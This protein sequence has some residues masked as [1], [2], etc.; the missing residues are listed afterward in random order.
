[1][2]DISSV[3]DRITKYYKAR[4]YKW[5]D[6]WEAMGWAVTE[7]GEV[8]E[9]LLARSGGWVR[10]NPDGKPLWDRK[11]FGDELGDVIMMLIVAGLVEGVDPINSMLEKIDR[12]LFSLSNG[13]GDNR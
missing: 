4:Q 2:A 12:K 13:S 11:N 9:I 1:M 3:S 6:T 5:P 10:N 7:I 8:Y